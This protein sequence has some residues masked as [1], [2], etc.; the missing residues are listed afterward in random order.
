[1]HWKFSTKREVFWIRV[2]TSEALWASSAFE[3]FCILRMTKFIWHM[4]IRNLYWIWKYK[5]SSSQLIITMMSILIYGRADVP[6][7]KEWD[8]SKPP[9][10]CIKLIQA[11][12]ASK[13]KYQV[14]QG[15]TAHTEISYQCLTDFTTMLNIGLRTNRKTHRIVL[16]V[17]GHQRLNCL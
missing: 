6:A 2:C 10:R 5:N 9:Q 3:M 13:H 15:P 14:L 12:T 8:A 17:S 1:M 7:W 16:R 4:S 11:S